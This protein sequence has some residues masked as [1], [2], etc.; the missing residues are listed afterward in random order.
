MSIKIRVEITKENEDGDETDTYNDFASPEA[1]NKWMEDVFNSFVEDTKKENK[2]MDEDSQFEGE[3]E[4][5]ELE[6][7]ETK[8][9]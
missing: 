1:A 9:E 2:L 8:E 5:R 7:L 4:Q 6:G 3:M